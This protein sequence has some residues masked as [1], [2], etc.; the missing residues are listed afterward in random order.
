VRAR[1][2]ADRALQLDA[3]I[4]EGHYIRGRLAWTPSAGWQHEYAINEIATALA[5]R[6]NLN[7]GFDRLA[8]ILYHVGLVDEAEALYKRATAINPDDTFAERLIGSLEIVRGNYIAAAQILRL[9]TSK[10]PD[11]WGSHQLA[12][13]QIR[14]GDLAAAEKTLDNAARLF[15]V[16]GLYEGLRAAIAALRGDAAGA[17]RAIDKTIHDRKAFGHFHHVAFDVACAYATLGQKE[18]AL[19]WLKSGVNDG[20]PCLMAVENEPLF[21]SLHAEPEYRAVITQLRSTREHYSDLF[22][23]LQQHI[24]S[25]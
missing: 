12:E 22:A 24:W 21:A 2:M 8:T 13:A 9:S 5:E 4:P 11:A 19:R 18:D 1:E 14:V 16:V 6:P 15:P 23:S 10:A 25:A 20:Y 7:E 3:N 17:Q